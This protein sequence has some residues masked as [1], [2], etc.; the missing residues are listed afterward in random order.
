[1][2]NNNFYSLLFIVLC[3][4]SYCVELFLLLSTLSIKCIYREKWLSSSCWSLT[5]EWI[6]CST[7]SQANHHIHSGELLFHWFVAQIVSTNFHTITII[8]PAYQSHYYQWF[9][10]FESIRIRLGLGISFSKL[11]VSAV[12]G[13]RGGGT[14]RVGGPPNYLQWILRISFCAVSF[15]PHTTVTK[16]PTMQSGERPTERTIV[17]RSCFAWE[18]EKMWKSFSEFLCNGI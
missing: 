10:W 1:M 3:V 17:F 12:H 15:I 6:A 11:M 5:T 18:T 8:G 9:R 7:R 16:R 14:L 4:S 2:Y 13:G